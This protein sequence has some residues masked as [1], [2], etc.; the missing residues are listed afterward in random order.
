MSASIE[1]ALLGAVLMATG[2]VGLAR[3]AIYLRVTGEDR[4]IFFPVCLTGVALVYV[5]SGG[6]FFLGKAALLLP[7]P[8]SLPAGVMAV[9]FVLALPLVAWRRLGPRPG[10]RAAEAPSRPAAVRSAVSAGAGAG[11][12]AAT[13]VP[14]FGSFEE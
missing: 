14:R 5:F 9:G 1:Y 6:A 11:A 13:A 10:G 3:A 7:S 4:E 2:S 12:G 8:W